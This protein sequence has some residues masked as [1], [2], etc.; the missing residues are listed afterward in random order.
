MLTNRI[1]P[2]DTISVLEY[3]QPT[4]KAVR[5]PPNEVSDVVF[6][7]VALNGFHGDRLSRSGL[8]SPRNC[9]W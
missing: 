7:G 3:G 9:S 2:Q 8:S 6:V 4:S 1:P 5:L